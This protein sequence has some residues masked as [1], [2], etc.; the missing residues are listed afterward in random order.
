MEGEYAQWKEALSQ[1]IIDNVKF[2]PDFPKKGVNFMDL[3]SLS[4]DP[5]LFKYINECTIKLIENE[6][7]KAHVDFNVIVG[8]ESRG[9]IQGPILAQ[10]FG[11]PF[12]PIR[13][14][15]KLPGECHKQEY[16]TEYSKDV[17]EIQKDS[18]KVG[19]KVLIG[20]DLLATGGTLKAAEDL[21]SKIEGTTVSASYCL[22]EIAVLKGREKLAGKMVSIVNLQD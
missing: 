19:A 22:F 14:Q 9:F 10:H 21:I 3:F 7:G 1:K 2:Y 17:C 5:G 13:K 6:V 11:V 8:L 4:S 16:G 20:D 12:V 18:L 15:G